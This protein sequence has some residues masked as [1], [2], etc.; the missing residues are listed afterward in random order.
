MKIRQILTIIVLVLTSCVQATELAASKVMRG[1]EESVALSADIKGV[2]EL[3]LIATVGPDTY[4]FDRAVWGNPQIVLDNG[5][6]VDLTTITPIDVSV[7]WGE[8]RINKGLAKEPKIGSKTYKSC[9]WAHA[10]SELSYKLPAKAI[11]FQAK[12][13]IEAG[14]GKGSVVFQVVSGNITQQRALERKL[15]S[16][17]TE[18][19]K[20]LIKWRLKKEPKQRAMLTDALTK[21]EAV[22]T[23]LAGSNVSASDESTLKFVDEMDALQR[24]MMLETIPSVNFDELLFIRRKSGRYLPQNWQSNSVLPKNKHDNKLC[25]LR[26]RGK[27]AGKVRDVYTPPNTAM[28]ADT[29][30]NWDG[31]RILFSSTGAKKAWHIF[32]MN[33]KDG[34]VRQ[35]S[36]DNEPDVNHYDACYLPDGKIMLTCTALKY[37]VPCVNGSAPVANLFRMN[38]DGSG[39]EMLAS[40]QEHSWCPTVMDDGR[41]MFLRWEYTDLPHSNSRIMFSC[42]PDGT[43]QRALYGSN[44][45]WPNGIFYARP[46]PGNPMQFIGIV[47]GHHGLARKGQLVLFDVNRGTHEADGAVQRIPGYGKTVKPL[48]RDRL[49]DGSWPLYLHPY[50]LDDTTFLVA[51]QPDSKS[52]MGLYLV[53]RFDNALL[54]SEES[55]CD[56]IEPIPLNPTPKPQVHPDRINREDPNATIYI[57]NIY[58]GPGL[59]GIPKGEVKELRLYTYTYGFAGQGGL[60]GVIGMDGPWDMRRMLGTVPVNPNGSALFNVPANTP[61]ALQPLD[62]EGKSLQVMRSW[63]NARNGEFLSCLGCHEDATTSPQTSQSNRP[64]KIATIEPW[65]GPYRNFEFAREIQPVLDAYC[66]SCHN[67]DDPPAA[68]RFGDKPWKPDLRGD[69]MITDW[70]TKMKGRGAAGGKFSISYANL[71]RFVRRPGIES[72]IQLSVPMEWH[73]DTTELML[74]LQKEHHNVKLSDEAM[75]RLITWMDFNAPYHGRWQTIA[76]SES[77]VSKEAVREK[78]RAMYASVYENHEKIDMAPVKIKVVTPAAEKPLPAGDPAFDGW[79]FNP[80]SRPLADAES[81]DLGK[82]IQLDIVSIPGGSFLMG[83]TDGYRDETPRSKV[84][85]KPF[86]MGRIEIT[87]RQFRRFKAN[88][89]SHRESRHGY[90]FGITGYEMNGDDQPAVRLSWDDAMAFCKWLSKKSGKKVSL[91]TEAQWEWAARAGSDKPFWY[92]ELDTDFST[93]ANLGDVSLSDFMGNPYEQDYKKAR[94]NNPENIYDNWVPQAHRVNDGGFI[95][96]ASGKWKA[97]PWG[98]SDMHGNVAEWTRSLYKPYPYKG[99]DGRNAPTSKEKRVVRGGSWWDRPKHAT[100][101]F[102]RAYRPYQPVY[103]VG[104]RI[105]IEE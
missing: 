57:A 91:P 24:K 72:D 40:D 29:D 28:I 11:R 77:A 62:A 12:V 1:G 101:S 103:N 94:C 9:L 26:I 46:I 88:H 80:S 67:Q 74:L 65:H 85:V 37:A 64:V 5:T 68:E 6:T 14:K 71:H 92:G 93:Y 4:D 104:F 8:L 49:A 89:T 60:Y 48:V 61:I 44:S 84:E 98:L 96:E 83:A 97:N 95:S 102:R 86:K 70:K 58:E 19:L 76:G 3:T 31:E 27:N 78:R 66:V 82:D 25:A 36:Q 81:L 17:N 18:A 105:V 52:R 21:V 34:T 2:K 47:T 38:A 55:G 51:M 75:D 43:N 90:Q 42:Y 15:K 16:V 7:G 13:G 45:F 20:R 79:P 54:L 23:M 63:F 100:A 35:V 41:V 39:M 33:L 10:P 56:L 73:A 69:K 22:K 53:D 87:N 32:E 59:K 99:K 30:L 50:P